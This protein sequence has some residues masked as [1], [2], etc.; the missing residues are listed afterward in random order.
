MTNVRKPIVK[1]KSLLSNEERKVA[2]L[3]AELE[4]SQSVMPR[5]LWTQRLSAGAKGGKGEA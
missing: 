1:I 4:A 5:E 3:V 2:D